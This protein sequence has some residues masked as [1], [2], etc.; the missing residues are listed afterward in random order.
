VVYDRAVEAGGRLAGI[1]HRLTRFWINTYA[2]HF[3]PSTAAL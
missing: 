1:G 3:N 2:R